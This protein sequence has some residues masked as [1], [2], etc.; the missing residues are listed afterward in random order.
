[1]LPDDDGV[2]VQVGDIGATNALGILLHDHP[3][4]V[5]VDEAFADRVGIFVGIG[6]SMV[7]AM[8]PGPPSDGT[9]DGSPAHGGEEDLQGQG[10]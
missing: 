4:K 1:V 8:I 3:S 9:F 5:G 6:V 2:I 7:G 10:G